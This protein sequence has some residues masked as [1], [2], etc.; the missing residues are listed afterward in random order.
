MQPDAVRLRRNTPTAVAVLANDRDPDG[1]PLQLSVV[2]PLPPGLEAV[3]D[4]DQL[5]VTARAG[6]AELVPFTYLVDDLNGNV[7]AGNGAGRHDRRHRAQP[8][9]AR[10]R[11]HRDRRRRHD[12]GDRRAV[13][14]QRPRRRSARSSSPSASLTTAPARRRSRATTCSSPPSPIV[15]D[16]ESR[17][18][19][20][21]Y[22]VSDANGHEV[23]G[24]IG[25]RVLSEPL[26]APP[27]ARDDTVTTQVDVAVTLDVLGNDGDPSGE[28][29]TLVG[30]PSCPSG[31][32]ATV[33]SDQRVTFTP[34]AGDVRCVPVHVRGDQPAQP[35]GDRVDHRQRGRADAAEPP[36][37]RDRRAGDGRRARLDHGRRARQRQ[38]PRRDARRADRAVVD[39]AELW[40]PPIGVVA[41]SRSPPAR[42]SA[43]P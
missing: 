10:H 39:D 33:T 22:T 20:F 11:R 4:G 21:T 18:V 14:R 5:R 37:A 42:C 34:P 2:T 29:P 36:A 15:D 1:D 19:R 35:A 8:P 30:A 43:R 7:V 23:A 26:A 27:Y 32:R 6:A 16:D 9:A 13:Q 3:V 24:E 31:G 41:R 25:V 28:R 17:I 38:R 40:G 12:T